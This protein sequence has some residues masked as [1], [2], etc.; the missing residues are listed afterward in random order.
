MASEPI[1]SRLRTLRK[2]SGLT[3]KELANVLGF[4][5]ELPVAEH[6]RSVTIPSLLTAMAYEVIFRVPIS[7]QFREVFATVETGVE[8][9]L[10]E[11]EQKL[12]ESREKGRGATLTARKLE[13]LCVRKLPNAGD[14]TA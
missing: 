7:E 8:E 11:L 13:F 1:A 14:T 2:K 3:Q 10:A 5:S 6:E 4:S 12:E 9:R